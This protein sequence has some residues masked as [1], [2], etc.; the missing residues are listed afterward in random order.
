MIT[1]EIWR[2]HTE[3]DERYIVELSAEGGLTKAAKV[4]RGGDPKRLVNDTFP[5]EPATLRKLS[6]RRGEFTVEFEL[7]AEG[8][9]WDFRG[10]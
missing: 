9:L 3:K 7:D 6:E 8:Y 1:R 2:H 4:E 5:P 10:G